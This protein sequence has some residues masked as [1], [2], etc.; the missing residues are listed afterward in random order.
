MVSNQLGMSFDSEVQRTL[1]ALASGT[2]DSLRSERVRR[3]LTLA[4]VAD[5]AGISRAL[6]QWLE[7]GHPVRLESYVR[8]SLALGLRLELGV[9]NPRRRR[10]RASQEDPV[11]AAMGEVIAARM[12][13]HGFAV[14][15]DEP[16]QHYQFAGRADVLAW[17]LERRAL[18][19]VENRT[20]FPNVQEAFGSYNAK[21]RFL[22]PFI[23]DRLDV[24]G[25]FDAVTHVV[26]ALWSSEVIHAIR[27]RPAS[28]RAVCRDGTTAWQAWWN[29]EPPGHGVTSILVLV[30]PLAVDA[31]RRTFV[32]LEEV[33]TVRPRYR[34]Y[35]DAVKALSAAGLG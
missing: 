12:S 17:S 25:G 10:G 34:G 6:V 20:R 27:L 32:G 3:R 28:F 11:H 31:R 22:A 35:A 26:A 8:V 24:R 16:F 4:Q 19:H 30:D 21:R 18:L 13:S 23:A 29:G 9:T 1:A 5:R 14:A 2:G 7:T 15:L 33:P